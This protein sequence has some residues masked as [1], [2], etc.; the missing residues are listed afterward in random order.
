[1]AATKTRGTVE[2][3]RLRETAFRLSHIRGYTRK[4]VADAIGI[5]GGGGVL[6]CYP[7]MERV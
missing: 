5:T 7:Y 2:Q 6:K 4:A 3:A 1:M